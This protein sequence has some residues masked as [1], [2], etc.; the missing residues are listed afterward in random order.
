MSK[1]VNI[2]FTLIYS[3]LIDII[4]STGIPSHNQPEK[5]GID[6]SRLETLWVYGD[7]QAERLYLSIR[8]GPLCT[9]IFKSCNLSKMWVYPYHQ[10][11]PPWDDKDYNYNIILDSLRAVLE[12]PEMNKNSVMILNLG[13]H[14]MESTTFQDY[15]LLIR[16]VIDILKE[17]NK[18]TGELKY[19]TRVIWKSSTSISKEKDTAGQLKSDR[20]R[21][22]ALPVTLSIS[23]VTHLTICSLTEGH[24]SG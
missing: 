1:G 20:R 3:Y 16:K 17:R 12:R 6:T 7:S 5:A 21:F 8:D 13:L 23:C 9:E 15:Q 4:F 19:Q 24:N 11:V 10:Q 22:L 18:E 2:F 14:Y